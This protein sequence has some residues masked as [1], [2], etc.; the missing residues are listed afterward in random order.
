[1]KDYE[2]EITITE[3]EKKECEMLYDERNA[4]NSLL[5]SL[6]DHPNECIDLKE[7]KL[8][9]KEVMILYNKWWENIVNKY[10]LIIYE[11]GN[12]YLD[13]HKNQIFIYRE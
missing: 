2:Y 8:R 12:R 10:N 6:K 1:M 11:N 13:F 5:K 3:Q 7:V 4:L 9:R